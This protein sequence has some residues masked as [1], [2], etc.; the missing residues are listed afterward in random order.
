MTTAKDKKSVET[1]SKVSGSQPEKPIMEYNNKTWQSWMKLIDHIP[2]IEDKIPHGV[3]APE[4][5][6]KEFIA[7]VD[8]EQGPIERKVMTM[9]RFKAKNREDKEAKEYLTYHED[10]QAKDWMGRKLRNSENMEGVY[11]EQEEEKIIRYH[12]TKGPHV[13]GYQRSGEHA[14]YTIPYSKDAVDQII[15]D[16]DKGDIRFTVKTPERRQQFLYDEFVNY[17]REQLENILMMD[18]GAAE[19]RINRIIQGQGNVKT[20][21]NLDFKP[22]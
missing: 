11:Y 5:R 3:V 7:Q 8:L 16:Q 22:S 9:V 10:W 21:N 15:G 6:K 18:G 20:A 14:V 1:E 19:A 13:A 17:S 4:Q 12:E 2:D